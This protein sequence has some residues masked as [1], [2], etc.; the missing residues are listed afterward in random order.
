M[1][2]SCFSK[3]TVA[4]RTFR[5]PAAQLTGVMLVTTMNKYGSIILGFLTFALGAMVW[6]EPRFWSPR[7]QMVIDLTNV[8]I[9]FVIISCTVGILLVITGIRQKSDGGNKY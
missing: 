1:I 2:R 8:R 5:W 4:A 3:N 7:Y 6:L 9:P